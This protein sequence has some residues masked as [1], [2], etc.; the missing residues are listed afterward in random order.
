MYKGKMLVQKPLDDLKGDLHKY[1]IVFKGE[2]PK[3]FSE[4]LEILN[5][6]SLGAIHTFIIK[7]N[8]YEIQ[9]IIDSFAPTV[10]EHTKLTLEEVFIYELG[11]LGYDFK[12]I[13][14]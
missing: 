9:G 10:C 8:G 7:G 4:K 6:T 5:E 12:A 1:Q 3:E 11:G 2:I 14:I 13:I